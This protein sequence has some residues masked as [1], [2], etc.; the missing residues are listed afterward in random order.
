MLIEAKYISFP[1]H[2]VMWVTIRGQIM[3]P[4]CVETAKSEFHLTSKKGKA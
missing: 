4:N 3:S 1:M 2:M